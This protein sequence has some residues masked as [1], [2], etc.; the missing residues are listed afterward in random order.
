[1]IPPDFFN[2]NYL[3]AEKARFLQFVLR[4]CGEAD[5]TKQ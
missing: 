2:N 5:K 3:F 4:H 1:M